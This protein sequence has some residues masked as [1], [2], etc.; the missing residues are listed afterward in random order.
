MWKR[1]SKIYNRLFPLRQA[2]SL[3]MVLIVWKQIHNNPQIISL[4]ISILSRNPFLKLIL[5]SSFTVCFFSLKYKNNKLIW[6]NIYIYIYI[7]IYLKYK[8][9]HDFKPDSLGIRV[10]NGCIDNMSRTRLKIV[11]A[12]NGRVKPYHKLRCFF[13]CIKFYSSRRRC[14]PPAINL[15]DFSTLLF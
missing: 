15:F 4:L 2:P 12:P 1:G 6:S 13:F 9:K 11:E 3:F 14:L 7:Y 10:A 5:N 8:N